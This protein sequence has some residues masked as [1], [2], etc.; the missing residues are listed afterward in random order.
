MVK[1]NAWVQIHKIILKPEERSQNLPEDTKK[2]PLEMWVKG[3]LLADA[4][5]NEVVSIKTTTGR[6]ETGVLIHENPAYLHTYGNFVP[7]ILEIDHIVKSAL[8]S[9]EDDE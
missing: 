7:E 9:G 6:I 5:I 3:R 4:C 8:S 1:K 2:V